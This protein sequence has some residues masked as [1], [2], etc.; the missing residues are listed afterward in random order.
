MFP[1]DLSSCSTYLFITALCNSTEHSKY[2][3]F[4]DTIKIA[5]SISCATD[6]TLP[7][8]DIA[9]IRGLCAADFM[10]NLKCFVDYVLSQNVGTQYIRRPTLLLL[11]VPYGYI[12]PQ[13]VISKNMLHLE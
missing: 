9:C 13:L 1:K 11:N 3:L 2:F 12:T 10:K 6:S 8:S 7:Q 4:A 5:F